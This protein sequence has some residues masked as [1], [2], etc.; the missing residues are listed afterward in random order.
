MTD[1]AQDRTVE[2]WDPAL[3]CFHW[4]LVGSFT[5]AWLSADNLDTIHEWSGYAAGAL[6]MF[7][8]LWGFA[9]PRYARFRQFVRT[10]AHV[11]AY[12]SDLARGR[13]SRFIG[14]NP[15]GGAMVLAL[16]AAMASL[17]VTGWMSTLDMFWGSEWL[18]EIHEFM[19]NFMLVLV[20]LHVAGVLLASLRHGEN[21][22]RAMVNGRKRAAE[23][24]DIV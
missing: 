24:G 5:I 12:L 22:V 18:E 15:A 19:A 8:L 4:C 23:S 11:L 14:H 2:V 3:R 16:M 13:E 6:I 17:A 10:P 21:L 20:G 7:R 9:G 1:G